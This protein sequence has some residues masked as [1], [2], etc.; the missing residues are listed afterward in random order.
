MSIGLCRFIKKF[1]MN[2]EKPNKITN[3]NM[4]IV[5]NKMKSC[6]PFSPFTYNSTK[7]KQKTAYKYSCF[8]YIKKRYFG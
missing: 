7:K 4:K 8:F 5:D 6:A 3:S 2:K 1:L